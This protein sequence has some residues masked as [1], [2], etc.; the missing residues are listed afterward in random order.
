[1]V[2]EEVF[3][4]EYSPNLSN[5]SESLYNSN[6]KPLSLSPLLPLSDKNYSPDGFGQERKGSVSLCHQ[7]RPTMCHGDADSSVALNP[8]PPQQ[9]LNSRGVQL[10][11]WAA[12]LQVT[13]TCVVKAVPRDD[14]WR[15]PDLGVGQRFHAERANQNQ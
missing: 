13:H 12:F 6:Y 7:P 4:R 9:R 3:I 8:N 5:N 14:R 1:M 2:T 15:T 11:G 10:R